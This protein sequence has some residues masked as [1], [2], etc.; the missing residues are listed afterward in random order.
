M[1]AVQINNKIVK[2]MSQIKDLDS[3]L[4]HCAQNAKRQ[5]LW[6]ERKKE[7]R[8]QGL[9]ITYNTLGHP[10]VLSK[11]PTLCNEIRDIQETKTLLEQPRIAAAVK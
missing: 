7:Q 8:N 3:K 2:N 6:R 1:E 5:R 9:D 4:H 11:Y 10:L